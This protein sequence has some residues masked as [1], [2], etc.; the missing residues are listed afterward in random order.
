MARELP[1]RRGSHKRSKR[2]VSTLCEILR[3][4]QDDSFVVLF[5]FPSN[6]VGMRELNEHIFERRSTLS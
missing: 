5:G 2:D 3:S 4:A 6:D 1:H